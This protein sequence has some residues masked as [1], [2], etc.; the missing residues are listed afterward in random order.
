MIL[1]VWFCNGSAVHW[2]WYAQVCFYNGSAEYEDAG[3]L[4]HNVV[5][6]PH[7]YGFAI[8]FRVG[9]A[10][11]MDLRDTHNPC[12]VY[13]EVFSVLPTA[14]EE[15]NFVEESCRVHDPHE[16]FNVSASALLLLP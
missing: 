5:E 9:D 8:L 14:V 2:F 11:L 1:L 3:S 13:S 16:I 12:C 7:S 4:A 10:L 15:Q 6:V